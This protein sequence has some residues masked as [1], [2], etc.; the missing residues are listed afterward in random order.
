MIQSAYDDAE[1]W[2]RFLQNGPCVITRRTNPLIL[3]STW[4]DG[5][6]TGSGGTI[7]FVS[8][9]IPVS[10]TEELWMGVWRELG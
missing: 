6:G 3:A 8:S 9:T 10:E 5:S 4:G 7:K 2:G 1:W